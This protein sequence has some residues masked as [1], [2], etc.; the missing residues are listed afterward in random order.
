MS[1]WLVSW[2]WEVLDHVTSLGPSVPAK[3]DLNMGRMALR[4]GGLLSSCQ[5]LVM[6]CFPS[7]LYTFH[8]AA[9][10]GLPTDPSSNVYYCY[11]DW[12]SILQ[13]YS[14]HTCPV[15]SSPNGAILLP[16]KVVSKFSCFGK[17]PCSVLFMP[18]SAEDEH[19]ASHPSTQLILHAVDSGFYP[20]LGP[21]IFS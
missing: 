13:T 17:Y 16:F 18:A 19:L 5:I 8:P 6:L 7:H 20:A 10:F 1:L 3:S 12:G 11:R 4:T 21:F 14:C 15:C 9:P 2:M